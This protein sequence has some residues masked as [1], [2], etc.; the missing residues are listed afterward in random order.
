M[1]DYFIQQKYT[2]YDL[3]DGVYDIALILTTESIEGSSKYFINPVCVPRGKDNEE[4]VEL[5]Y[6]EAL[7]AGF[8]KTSAKGKRSNKL[9]V[10]P[11]KISPHKHCQ[12]ANDT[13]Y[14][15]HLMLYAGDLE[16]NHDACTGY[17][18]ALV[19][20]SKSGQ[21]VLVGITS[22]GDGSVDKMFQEFTLVWNRS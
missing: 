12:I 19:I 15:P 3:K 20:K 22:F 21:W 14:D 11:V 7:I 6:Q 2:W 16:D 18:G 5:S 9:Q 4:A 17:S 13:T 8:G 1:K 10:S